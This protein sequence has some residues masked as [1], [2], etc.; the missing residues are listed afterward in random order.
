M[1]F[2]RTVA[3]MVVGYIAIKTLKRAMKT[4]EVQQAKAK[5]QEPHSEVPMK[6]LKLDPVTGAYVPEA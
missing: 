5:V 1:G 4:V 2:F 6:R 3:M